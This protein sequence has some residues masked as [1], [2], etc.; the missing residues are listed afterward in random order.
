MKLFI[1]LIFVFTL[2]ISKANAQELFSISGTVKSGDSM[3]SGISV[4]LEGTTL[5]SISDKNGKFVIKNIPP[6]NYTIRTKALGFKDFETS[7][8]I[9]VQSIGN[10]EI[11]IIEQALRFDELIVT[12]TMKEISIHD[13]PVKVNSISQQF[14]QKSASTSIMDAIQYVNGL[15]NQVDCA[16]CGT[17]NIRINGMEGPYTAVL[18]DG[19]PIMSSL[20]SIYGLNGINTNLIRNIEIIKG[21]SSTLYGSSAMAGVIN[22]RTVQ[23]ETAPKLSLNAQSSTYLENE[24][25]LSTSFS[26]GRSDVLFGAH[27]YIQNNYFDQN[28]DSFSDIPQ[29]NRL[30][31]FS[32]INF[33]QKKGNDFNVS[34]KLYLEDRLGGV[35]DYSHGI[36]GSGEVYGESIYTKRAELLS[37][38]ELPF[39]N[40]EL[41]VESSYSY[42]D[43]D[44]YYGSYQYEA[45]QHTAFGNLIWDK[46]WNTN[47]NLIVGTSLTY[48]YLNQVFDGNRLN[49]GSI[50]R[51]LIPSIYSQYDHVFT[52]HFRA[53]AGLRVEN[54]ENHGLVYSPRFNFKY[55]NDF[56]TTLRLNIGTGFRNV[57][58]FTE[59]HEALT[60]GRAVV[61]AED[62]QPE[63]SNNI[64]LNLNQIVEI[65]S[66]VLNID[67]DLYHTRFSN[68]ILP[69][70][71]TQGIIL[72]RN[73]DGFSVSR[74]VSLSATHNFLKPISYTVGVT[75]QDIFRVEPS[76]K[77]NILFA[78]NFNA[79]FN[80]SY[81]FSESELSLDYTSRLIG[82]MELPEYPNRDKFSKV[83]SEHNLKASKRVNSQISAFFAVK[84]M[85]NFTQDNAIIDS[86]NPFSDDFATDYI[87]GPLQ[88]RRLLAGFSLLLN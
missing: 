6:A 37:R 68:Q 80:L 28:G 87:Y 16:V 35:S 12:G 70:Y 41:R 27:T 31:I 24:I 59:E 45:L 54:H 47:Q 9:V 82:K 67:L 72:Y 33:N 51:K 81:T 84:N 65:N 73:L 60:G 88:G 42:H 86:N 62:L 10:L 78:P 48:D 64:A 14:I 7:V 25:D 19:M 79:V 85:F 15:Y 56:E 26:A 75:F 49:G 17:N 21:P 32:K 71:D 52:S 13:S 36:R 5:G 39:L 8:S 57:N 77:E 69:N 1:F 83:F 46:R 63:Q 30:N 38:Y 50:D 66:S 3:V 22:I 4:F 74:G 11:N 40:Q 2:S 53:L 76:G 58:L 29:S 43:Q 20:A 23:T 55:S 61:I 18:I 34:A 44:S